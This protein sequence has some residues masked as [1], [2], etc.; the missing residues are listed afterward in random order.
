MKLIREKMPEHI[1]IILDGNGRWAK[2]RGLSRSVGHKMGY[3]TLKKRIQDAFDLGIKVISLYAFS[4]ENWKRPQEEIDGLYKIVNEFFE[5]DSLNLMENGARLQLMG[6]YSVFPQ[7]IVDNANK[8][9]EQTKDNEKHIL[10]IGVNYGG[11]DE[12]VVA[13]NKCIK[14]GKEEIT[15]EDISNNLYT[16]NLPPL[17]FVI[18]TSGEQR[19]SNF[20]R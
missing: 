4:T 8:L 19:L 16:S 13:V 20:N 1:G 15:K 6:D 9:I 11:Q 7:E 18:R 17:D 12:L 3:L 2:K 5:K 14:D 10:N